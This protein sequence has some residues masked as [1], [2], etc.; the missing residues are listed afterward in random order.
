MNSLANKALILL[1]S[2]LFFLPSAAFADGMEDGEYED[3]TMQMLFSSNSPYVKNSAPLWDHVDYTLQNQ[4]QQVV[5]RLGLGSTVRQG[6]L[7]LS[8][9]DISDLNRPRVAA[10]NGDKMMYA[11]SLPKI[12]ILLGAFEKIASGEISLDRAN[13]DQLV[14]MIRVSS[15][16]D[17]TAMLKKVGK[18]D[19]AK[20]LASDRYQL[21]DVRHNGGL[22]VGKDYGRQGLWR[23]DPMHNL[24]HGATAMQVARFYYML[25]TGQLVNRSASMK[26]KAILG[27]PGISHKF[28]GGLEGY[29][30]DAKIFRKSGSWRNFHSDSA[31]IEHKGARYIA[32]ALMEH[33]N[34]GEWLKR[35]I[36]VMDRLVDR[37]VKHRI[38]IVKAPRPAAALSTAEVAP[39]LARAS[40][41]ATAL[42]ANRVDSSLARASHTATSLLKIN[43]A[44]SIAR[45]SRAATALSALNIVPSVARAS[46]TAT[47]MS[48]E[49]VAP[50]VA[51]ASRTATAYFAANKMGRSLA[52]SSHNAT[53]LSVER[54]SNLPVAQAPDPATT[55]TNIKQSTKPPPG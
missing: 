8:L 26:M 48:A 29:Q 41:A 28:V 43:A 35:L 51:R 36:R 9:V 39:S 34:G 40:H 3:D 15:N 45:A 5:K 7:A 50:S 21:Y 2:A 24:S 22:W 12:A 42:S 33:K 49:H 27:N 47:A 1:L 14:R 44:P 19:L 32:V 31:I 54:M 20:I 55:L 17:A 46:H 13:R 38:T 25:E 23:R 18:Q 30:P 52:R 10:I 16:T 6:R 4:L 53:A 11:A 37:S